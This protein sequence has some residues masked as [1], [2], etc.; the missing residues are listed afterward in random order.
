MTTALTIA[1]PLSVSH[2]AAAAASQ[3]GPDGWP[4][5]ERGAD[6]APVVCHRLLARRVVSKCRDRQLELPRDELDEQRQ[7]VRG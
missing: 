6:F 1:A 2:A 4:E 5:A 7:A 3:V